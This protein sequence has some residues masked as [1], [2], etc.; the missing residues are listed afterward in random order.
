VE[1]LTRITDDNLRQAY[2]MHLVQLT[3]DQRQAVWVNPRQIAYLESRV[4]LGEIIGTRLIFADTGPTLDV[5][6]MPDL[7]LRILENA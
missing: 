2:A 4:R 6:E 5:A 1:S 3:S 7:V